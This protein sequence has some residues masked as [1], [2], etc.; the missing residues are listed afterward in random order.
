M[1]STRRRSQH[2]TPLHP[3][4]FAGTSALLTPL[5]ST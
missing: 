3:I 4:A 5:R 2:V 1:S